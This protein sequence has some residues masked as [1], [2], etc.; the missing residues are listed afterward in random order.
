MNFDSAMRD[1]TDTIDTAGFRSVVP[2]LLTVEDAAERLG[3]GRTLMRALVAAHEVES[4]RIGRLRRIPEDALGTYIRRLR[5]SGSADSK[6][7]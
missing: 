7:V 5:E 2:H 1:R 3:V 6:A 4:V